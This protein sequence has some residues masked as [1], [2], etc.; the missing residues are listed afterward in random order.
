ML[1]T[2]KLTVQLG[3][4]ILFENVS[5][6]FTEGNAYGIIGANGSGKSTFLKVLSKEIEP[7]HGTVFIESSR[8]LSFLKQDHH[9][10][11]DYTVLETVIMG[12]TKLYQVM[13]EKDAIYAKPDFNDEDGIR[14]G[15]LEEIFDHLGGWDAEFDAAVLLNGLGLSTEYH[16]EQ[17]ANLD[18]KLKVKVLLAQ[19]LFGNPDVLLLDEPTNNLDIAAI[20]WLE[21]FLIE[22][23]NTL[24]IVSH[25]RYFLNKVCT[26]IADIDYKEI[27]LYAGNYDFWYESSQL[28]LK[29][30]KDANKKSEEKIKELQDFIA[31]FSANASKSKQATSR[32]K[33]LD[34]IEVSEIKPST[35]R[36]PY[37]NFQ[38]FKKLGD[39]ILTVEKLTKEENGKKL[40][41]NVSFVLGKNDKVAFVGDNEKAKTALFEIL[42]GNDANYSGSFKFGETVSKSYFPRDNSKI[43]VRNDKIIDWLSN[44]TE[45]KEVAFL[46]GFLGRMLFSGDDVF[47][48]IKVLSGGEK[49]RVLLS[50]MMLEGS[51]L[52]IF[53]EPTHH[54]DMESITSLNKG[55]SSFEGV[56][57][58]SS[59][60]H[61]L[62]QTTA[63][64]IIEIKED[65]TIID[66]PMTYDEYLEIQMKK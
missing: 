25:D 62:V 19:A 55:M 51:N 8:R 45:N 66:Q 26:H 1:S 34:K 29:Q 28:M 52:M 4:E 56:V 32:K 37:V 38:A 43:F 35:R 50:R 24:I 48:E 2:N 27:R 12:N 47:K 17:M 13:K 54:L 36:Y 16:Y 59:T 22:F 5:I 58:F 33:L 23:K 30:A 64:R 65:G 40:L 61:E 44:Y 7:T 11:D 60:D 57:L 63:N 39:D 20:R 14:A 21:E 41:N 10:Y 18:S 31:R 46:R 53:D 15:K 49:V 9:A 3:K 42:L 6:K